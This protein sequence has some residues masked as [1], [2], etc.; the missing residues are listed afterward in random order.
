MKSAWHKYTEGTLVSVTPQ[1]VVQISF[2]FPETHDTERVVFKYHASDEAEAL[3]F[4]NEVETRLTVM[5]IYRGFSFKLHVRTR[6][7]RASV[8]LDG[9]DK[10][11]LKS[12]AVLATERAEQKI[13]PAG[14]GSA[15]EQ[16]ASLMSDAER[17]AW[18]SAGM[19]SK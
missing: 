13:A 2:A 16:R 10:L 11:V 5:P 6:S 14:P 1:H 12:G 8:H 18:I 15:V 7:I 3:A 9:E 4:V 19:P 17:E